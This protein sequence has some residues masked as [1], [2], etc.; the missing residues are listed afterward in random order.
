MEVLT[1]NKANSVENT[2]HIRVAQE[3]SLAGLQKELDTLTRMRTRDLID[4]EAF[5]KE[6][7]LLRDAIT[8]IK[9]QLNDTKD[10]SGK[11]IELSEKA[12]HYSTYARQKFVT[13]TLEAQK[14]IFIRLGSNFQLKD[15]RLIFEASEWLLQ[16]VKDYP[17]LYAE[18]KRLELEKN[19]TIE[20]Q[21]LALHSIILRWCAIEDSNL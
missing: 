12:F 15:G 4:D 3:Q 9:G 20:M 16:I 1:K 17:A 21:K 14:D 18:Y 8:K 13:G 7:E 11:W 19:L 5:I 10:N 6:R 2:A